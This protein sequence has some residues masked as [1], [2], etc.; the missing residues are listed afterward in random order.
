MINWLKQRDNWHIIGGVVLE[1]I[2]YILT[3]EAYQ[4]VGRF[5]FSTL[6]VSAGCVIWEMVREDRRG[7]AFDWADI[8]RGV[9]AAL[10][11]G[12]LCVGVHVLIIGKFI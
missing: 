11:T 1:I 4:M 2:A 9:Y 3:F 10:A 7:Y 8:H 5:L 12:V 6:L